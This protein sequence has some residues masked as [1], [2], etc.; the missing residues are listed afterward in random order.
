MNIAA[1]QKRLEE[2][3]TAYGVVGGHLLDIIRLEKE[4]GEYFA[5]TYHGQ[6]V[7]IDSFQSFFVETLLETQSWVAMHAWPE[8]GPYFAPIY[9][10]YVTIFRS[11]RACENLLFC[12]YPLDGCGLMRDLKD[13]ALFLCALA[14][15]ITTFPAIHGYSGEKPMS[16]DDWKTKIKGNPK[17]EEKRIL[18][19]MIRKKS[20]LPQDVLSE[21]RFWEELF[22]EEVHGSKLSFFAES[23]GWLTGKEVFSIGPVPKEVPLGMYMNRAA[24]IGWLFVRL[25]PL[26]QPVENAFGHEWIERQ[27]ILDDSF[28]F[29]VTGLSKL[30]KKIADAFIYFVDAKFSFPRN[31]H[32]FEADGKG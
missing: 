23:A 24:E 6:L 8:T 2:N 14:R 3:F 18:G 19:R 26:L 17:S 22:H 12:G 29:M 9:S 31:L 25:L 1:W 5:R 15:N 11:Y 27:L 7:L 4:Y 21:L 20:G 16:E 32:Y 30:G 28:R 13:R 10:F